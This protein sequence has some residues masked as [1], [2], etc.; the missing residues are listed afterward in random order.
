M[1][2]L[3]RHGLQQM[4]IDMNKA[5]FPNWNHTGDEWYFTE[6]DIYDKVLIKFP[7]PGFW[8]KFNSPPSFMEFILD[9]N[10]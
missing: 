10:I 2:L 6:A 8:E 5:V 7:N 1:V 3:R 4:S 9:G